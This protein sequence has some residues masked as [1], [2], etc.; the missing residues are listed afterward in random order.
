MINSGVG[1]EY[2]SVSRE[3]GG[4]ITPNDE[5]RIVEEDGREAFSG[6]LCKSSKNKAKDNGKEK[7]LK[8]KPS[9]AENSL[10]ILGQEVPAYKK[11]KQVPVLP[12]T[13]KVKSRP[14]SRWFES[15]NF[16]LFLDEC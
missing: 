10:L 6:Y 13:G 14:P 16:L 3:A 8:N 12:Y 11:V 7:G 9:G 4:K 2:G 15:G 5:S 1:R